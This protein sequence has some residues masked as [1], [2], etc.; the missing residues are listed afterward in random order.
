[1]KKLNVAIVGTA[2]ALIAMPV[3]AFSSNSTNGTV[4]DHYKSVIQ[5]QPYQVEVCQDVSISGD[6]TSDTFRGAIL[7]GIIGN[8]ITKN[9]PDGGTAG[10]ILGGILG[11][12]NSDARGGTQRQC[13]LQTRYNEVQQNDIYSHSTITFTDSNGKQHTLKF[14]K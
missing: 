13:S 6:R 1:M 12:M 9:M 14:R 2:L 7:G 4:R 10:A 8:N 5:Q 11:N 3:Q